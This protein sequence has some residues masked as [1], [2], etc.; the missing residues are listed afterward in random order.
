M[1]QLEKGKYTCEQKITIIGLAMLF[2]MCILH[3][4]PAGDCLDFVPVNGTFQNFNPI[5]RLLAGQIPGKDFYDYLGMGHLI[6]GSIT[7]LLFGKDFKAS[8]MA[9]SFLSILSLVLISLLISY[10][11]FKKKHLSVFYTNVVLILLLTQHEI[12]LNLLT[13]TDEVKGALNVALEVGNSARYIRGMILPLSCGLL[14]FGYWCYQIVS[15][16]K[17]NLEKYKR[18][19]ISCGI[20]FV[21]GSSFVWSNDFGISCWLC[22]SLMTFILIFS[23]TRKWKITVKYT[24]IELFSSF[25]SVFI[26][27]ELFTLG[28]MPEWMQFTFGTGGYQKWYYYSD[29]SYYIYNVDFSYIMLVQASCCVIY[30]FK[31]YMERAKKEAVIRYGIPAFANMVSFCMANEYRILSGGFVREVALAVL[32]L[33]ISSEVCN[34]IIEFTGK[35]KLQKLMVYGAFILGISW[36]GSEIQREVISLGHEEGTYVSEMGGYMI[37]LADDLKAANNFLNGEKFFSTY[38][39]GQEVVEDKYQPSG[40]DYIIH[41][42]G[43]KQREDYLKSFKT[44]DFKY[45][46]TMKETYTQYEYWIERANWFFYR[47]L[48]NNWHPIYS[49]DY[50]KY[51]ERNETGEDNIRGEFSV[52]IEDVNASAKKIIIDAG[53]ETISGYADLYIDYAVKK[54]NSLHSKIL[55]SSLLQV[56]NVGTVYADEP[57]YEI[58]FLRSSGG[59]Y[60]PVPLVNGHGE[61]LLNSLPE[62]ST[63]LELYDFS[64]STLYP[65]TFNYIGVNSIFEQEHTA[66]LYVFNN[67]K[68]SDILKNSV[69]I[70]IEGTI[71]NIL[72]IVPEENVLSIVVDKN[73]K[74]IDSNGDLLSRKNY[75]YVVR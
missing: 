64:C 54:N 20:G 22:L 48:Y 3:A 5:R 70:N 19:V 75:F 23:R 34:L 25:A 15:L 4:I 27:A 10:S 56:S 52:K 31:I 58:N 61:I 67:K 74:K 39:S 7:T 26:I 28:H 6:I 45:A 46:A 1:K 8:L 35:E 72:D 41:V 9:F 16:K 29:K 32:F 18:L 63:Y 21:A 49:N 60:I 65:V 2:V 40:V 42:L 24:L 66:I 37:S 11:V 50:E 69:G 53:D 59:E 43:D 33:T 55:I 68:N 51:W 17:K 73:S 62:E 13:G 47:E 14:F 38:A 57:W 36:I 44:G 71:Y 12:F 30:L